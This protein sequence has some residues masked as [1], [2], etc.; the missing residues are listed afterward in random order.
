MDLMK[1][2]SSGATISPR[3]PLS[4]TKPCDLRMVSACPT[5]W[6]A[7]TPPPPVVAQKALRLEDGERRPDG[8]ARDGQRRRQLVLVEPDARREPAFANGGEDCFISPVDERGGSG[9]AFDLCIPHRIHL[10]ATCTKGLEI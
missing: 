10:S 2:A 6:R 7:N 4:R 9:Q 3:R 1:S 5:G 8:L